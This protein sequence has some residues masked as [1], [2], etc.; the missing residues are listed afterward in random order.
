LAEVPAIQEYEAPL[1]QQGDLDTT[2]RIPP[3]M[4]PS[5][6]QA[7]QYF[8]Y[9]FDNIHPYVPVINRSYFYRQWHSDRVSISPLILEAI[10]A[11]SSQMLNHTLEGKQW[12]ALASS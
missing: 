5:E 3:G 4:M 1:P 7:M 12:L 9:F 8:Q 10:F 11:C 6:Q 2:V